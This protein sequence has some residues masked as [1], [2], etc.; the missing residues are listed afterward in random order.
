MK[1][2]GLS[3]FVMLAATGCTKEMVLEELRGMFIP[4][5]AKFGMESQFEQIFGAFALGI[6]TFLSAQLSKL[7]INF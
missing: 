2:L 3:V 5:L 4:T 1:V 6:A 7:G